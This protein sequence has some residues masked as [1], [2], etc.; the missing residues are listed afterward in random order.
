[1]EEK[2][3]AF[4]EKPLPEKTITRPAAQVDMEKYAEFRVPD[5]F[6]IYLRKDSDAI[7]FF[8]K[9]VREESVVMPWI[10]FIKSKIEGKME[11]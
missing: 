3:E 7:K 1:M 4:E 2:R 9:Q 11:D 10:R 6:I 5:A 8:E